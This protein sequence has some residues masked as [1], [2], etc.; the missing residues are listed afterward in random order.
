MIISHE[1]QNRLRIQF[2][3]RILSCSSRLLRCVVGVIGSGGLVGRFIA[4]KR[5]SKQRFSASNAAI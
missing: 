1:N 5:D 2:S 4:I 3:L